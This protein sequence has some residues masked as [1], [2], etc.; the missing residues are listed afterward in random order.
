MHVMQIIDSVAE[1]ASGP[2]YTVPR[3]CSALAA[4]QASVTL[5][6]IGTGEDLPRSDFDHQR[7]E[8]DYPSVPILSRLRASRGLKHAI[9]EQ[10]KLSDIA[11]SHGLWLMANVYPSWA[12]ARERKP[13]VISPRGMLGAPA[14]RFSATAKRAFWLSLQG[15]AVQFASCIHATSYQE[16]DDIRAFGLTQPVAIIP[17]GIDLPVLKRQEDFPLRSVLYLGRVHPKKGLKTLIEAW[18][19]IE[20]GH[21]SWELII[22][23]PDESGYANE[24][25]RLIVSEGLKRASLVGPLYGFEK[26]AAYQRAG[27]FVLPTLNENFGMVVAEALA[28][29]TPV[30]CTQGAPWSGLESEGAG[31]WI[32]NSVDCLAQCLNSAL[33]HTPSELHSMGEK[34]RAWM[35]R[36]FAWNAV[37]ADTMKLYSWLIQEGPCPDFVITE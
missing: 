2:S 4:R 26:N 13:L 12:A 7:F 19:E 20:A 14:L 9:N 3:L 11:H 30:I 16:Y 1:E 5:L 6:S 29:A 37:G 18:A 17:N 25:S 28:N 21:P 33:R 10:M 22:A 35:E 32:E 15:S 27:V 24:L 34:G 23:G 36:D 31:W 8:P